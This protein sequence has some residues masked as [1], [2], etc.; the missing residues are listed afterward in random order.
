MTKIEEKL[1][2][3]MEVVGVFQEENED[4]QKRL[5]GLKN[6]SDHVHDESNKE[7]E[8]RYNFEAYWEILKKRRTNSKLKKLTR[9][10]VEMEKRL[11]GSL[12]M[13]NMLDQTDLLHSKWIMASHYHQSSG[14]HKWTCIADLRTQS[15]IWRTSKPTLPSTALQARLHA[16]LSP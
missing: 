12:S 16:K 15:T 7:E 9:K 6:A 8:V 2:K 5:A 1:A 4:L 3:V 14:C 10:Y 13:Q 11:R